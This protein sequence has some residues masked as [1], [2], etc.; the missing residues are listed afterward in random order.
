VFGVPS[1]P[2]PFLRGRREGIRVS[3][4]R[5]GALCPKGEKEKGILLGNIPCFLRKR[6]K[7]TFLKGGEKTKTKAGPDDRENS[8]HPKKGG[9]R[10]L[11]CLT[12]GKDSGC[13]V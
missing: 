1:D 6:K 8:D 3:V 4:L 10:R 12:A 7:K 2:F 13:F 9:D 11:R 5:P